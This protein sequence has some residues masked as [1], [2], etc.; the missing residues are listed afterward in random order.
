[1]EPGEAHP[2]R[3]FGKTL[4]LAGL[5]AAFIVTVIVTALV[6][7]QG[8]F[9]ADTVFMGDSLIELWEFPAV[10]FGGYGNTTEQ[11]RARFN[12]VTDAQFMRAVI[13]GG[14]NDVLTGIAPETT[15]GNLHEMIRIATSARLET[16]VGTIPD[17]YVENGKYQAAVDGLNARI[18]TEIQNWNVGGTKVILLDFNRALRGRRNA[19]SDDGLHLRRRGYLLMDIE[20]LRSVNPFLWKSGHRFPD[21]ITRDTCPC[22]VPSTSR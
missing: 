22:S 7:N 21:Q 1:M 11:I 3:R 19:Y 6:V 10:N 17:I 18:R 9:A 12:E 15:I 16:F 5:L 14:T 4:I 8:K 2:P 20:L 13:L